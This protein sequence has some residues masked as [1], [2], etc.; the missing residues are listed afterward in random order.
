MEVYGSEPTNGGSSIFIIIGRMYLVR[1]MGFQATSSL[2]F[3][4]IV[5][6]QS[7]FPPM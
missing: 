2:A 6:A 3:L 1:Q 4:K 7:G 5:K